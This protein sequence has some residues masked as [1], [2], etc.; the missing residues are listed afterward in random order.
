MAGGRWTE[1]FNAAAF[2]TTKYAKMGDRALVFDA[3]MLVT[4]FCLLCCAL[5]AA[6]AL[7]SVVRSPLSSES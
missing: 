7:L 2:N 3:A 1:A 6:A 5:D 4:L